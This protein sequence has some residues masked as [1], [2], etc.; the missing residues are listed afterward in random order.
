MSRALLACAGAGTIPALGCGGGEADDEGRCPDDMIRCL[1]ETSPG[2]PLYMCFEPSSAERC[3]SCDVQCEVGESCIDRECV[4]DPV[5]Q[6]YAY[7]EHHVCVLRESGDVVC[8]GDDDHGA[9]RFPPRAR[10]LSPYRTPLPPAVELAMGPDHTR[11]RTEAGEVW[12]QGNPYMVRGAGREAFACREGAVRPE[13]VEGLPEVVDQISAEGRWTC[14]TAGGRAYCWGCSIFLGTSELFAPGPVLELPGGTARDV[15]EIRP[16]YMLRNAEGEVWHWRDVVRDG[17]VIRPRSEFDPGRIDYPGT[18]VDLSGSGVARL[19]SGD[20]YAW[21]DG[22]G[23]DRVPI[24]E[25][26]KYVEGPWAVT[27]SGALLPLAPGEVE[28]EDT[29]LRNVAR[30][31]GHCALLETGELMCMDAADIYDEW[32][33]IDL[34]YDRVVDEEEP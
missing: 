1:W 2:D 23:V 17:E 34:S 21:R 16:V 33:H 10:V 22:H 15:E 25:R 18:V 24:D 14:A 5:V 8:F 19:D 30:A 3:G 12:C 29:G 32:V 26:V 9:V 20:V 11:V 6:M 28:I 4:R 27:E 7:L 13:R 31:D